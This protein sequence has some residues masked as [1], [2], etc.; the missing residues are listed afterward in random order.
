MERGGRGNHAESAE[1]ETPIIGK[2]TLTL[3]RSSMHDE[4]NYLPW[5]EYHYGFNQRLF[6]GK[7]HSTSLV[8]Q[9][10]D[11]SIHT[12]YFERVHPFKTTPILPLP[13]SYLTITILTDNL[14][15]RHFPT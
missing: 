13:K 9:A 1:G 3:R 11:F 15:N 10:K 2:A 8:I 4:T 14:F 5:P 12:L 7:R 6:K